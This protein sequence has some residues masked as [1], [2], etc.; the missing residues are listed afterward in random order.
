LKWRKIQL[1]LFRLLQYRLL[2]CRMFIFVSFLDRLSNR[3]NKEKISCH[4]FSF[5]V[6]YHRADL[7]RNVEIEFTQAIVNCLDSNTDLR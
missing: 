2:S 7:G 1:L 3:H 4:T 6:H 5:F